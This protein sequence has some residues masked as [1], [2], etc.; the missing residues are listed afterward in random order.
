MDT[1]DLDLIQ[2]CLVCGRKDVHF[3]AV[4]LEGRKE[5]VW[6]VVCASCGQT[7]LQ[8]SVSQG[9]AIRAW[10]RNLAHGDFA[11]APDRGAKK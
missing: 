3:E 6:R 10:N 1:H 11:S 5:D 8:W 9:A 2:P 7:S 4:R